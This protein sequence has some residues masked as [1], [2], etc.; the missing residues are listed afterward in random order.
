MSSL[1]PAP[2]NTAPTPIRRAL[3]SVSDKSGVLDFAR[4]LVAC[5][6][7]LLSTGGTAKLLAENGVHLDVKCADGLC[8]VC[9][10]GLVSGAV[11]HRDFVLSKAQRETAVILC[12]SRAA[13]KDGV[14]A[15]D[16]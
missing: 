4:A 5:G 15:V 10:C 1:A 11:E 3:L 12:Q 13:E 2:A 7:E 9:K 14:I 8:G 16:L 6:V